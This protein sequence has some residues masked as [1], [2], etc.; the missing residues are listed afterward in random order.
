M[1]RDGRQASKEES[2]H[3]RNATHLYE[4]YNNLTE[5]EKIRKLKSQGEEKRDLPCVRCI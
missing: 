3:K 4:M 1:E 2:R 5:Y